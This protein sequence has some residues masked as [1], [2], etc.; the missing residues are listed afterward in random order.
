MTVLNLDT[1]EVITAITTTY[2]N[3]IESWLIKED[4]E[5]LQIEFAELVMSLY[6]AYMDDETEH[7]LLDLIQKKHIPIDEIV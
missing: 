6:N 1:F 2:Q 3:E 4:G 5:V 7:S